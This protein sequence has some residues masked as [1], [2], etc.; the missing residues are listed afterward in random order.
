MSRAL[1]QA[2]NAVE[3]DETPDMSPEA[4]AGFILAFCI[5]AFV[6]LLLAAYSV[7]LTGKVKQL[8]ADLQRLTKR[9][10]E[11]EKDEDDLE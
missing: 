7:F 9:V 11:V 6:L 2:L 5:V 10:K 1:L 8:A 4:Q 3:V